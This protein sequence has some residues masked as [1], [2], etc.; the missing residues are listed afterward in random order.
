MTTSAPTATQYDG[1]TYVIPCGAGKLDHPAPARDLY[2][3]SMFRHTLH[4]ALTCASM[5]DQPARVLILSAR[6]GLLELD[7]V[8]AP[9]DLRMD[10]PGSI[11]P[12]QLTDQAAALGIDWGS[13]V[14]ALLPRP[15]LA[16][17][18]TALRTLDVYVQD[19]Y[20]AAGGIGD[21]KHINAVIAIPLPDPKPRTRAVIEAEAAAT[22]DPAR[23]AVL[24]TE[25]KATPTTG[26]V[27]LDFYLGGDVEALRWGVPVMV[28]YGRL[29]ERKTIPAG[30]APVVID[31]RGYTE[32]AQH[33]RWTIGARE[34]AADLRR[35]ADLIGR[36]VWASPQDWICSA[37]ILAKTGLT[38]AEH[39]QRTVESVLLL[40]ALNPGV[41]IIPV[42]QGV[43]LPGYLRHV[44]LYAAHGVDL[45]AETTVGVGSLVGRS[46]GDVVEIVTA[47][48]GLGLRLHGFGVK[49]AVLAVA[50][51]HFA[52]VD[53]FAWAAGARK[54]LG[55]CPHGLV[56]LETNCPVYAKAWRAGILARL[57]A[58]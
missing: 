44:A 50:A 57:R 1:I 35:Y 14:Y 12:A 16:R 55:A 30:T 10:Q 24:R 38:E 29:R 33:G 17:L 46:T 22:T 26:P 7:E 15:Y 39:Q 21:Q 58:A 49:G 42:L 3:G 37:D 54:R 36:V 28:S 8:I 5:D 27:T 19:V 18:D 13:A 56:K 9:Y 47:L 23:L 11:T 6:Y 53:S 40:R 31:S 4:S 51:E 41:H 25:W 20:E 45:V 2:T 43:D 52:S 34:Y 48:A 32:L